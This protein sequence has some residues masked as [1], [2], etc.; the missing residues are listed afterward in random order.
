MRKVPAVISYITHVVKH[1]A[2]LSHKQIAV[3]RYGF[4]RVYMYSSQ[5]VNYT[6]ETKE[7]DWVWLIG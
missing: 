7:L 4:F 2:S 3:I 6:K 5:K 1:N